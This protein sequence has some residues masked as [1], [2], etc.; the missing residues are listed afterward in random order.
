MLPC[1]PFLAFYIWG[2]HWRHLK[3]TTESSMC[4][5]DAALCQIT[6]TMHLLLLLLCISQSVAEAMDHTSND[7]MLCIARYVA[8]VTRHVGC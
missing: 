8:M 7:Q 5:G 3:N 4:G 6:L 2:A 1:Q